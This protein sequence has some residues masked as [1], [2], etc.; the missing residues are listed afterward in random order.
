M[1]VVFPA[2]FSPTNPKTV[3]AGTSRLRLSNASFDP[4]RRV[5]SRIWTAEAVSCWHSA[6]CSTA[7]R[8]AATMVSFLRACGNHGAIALVQQI[9]QILGGDIQLICLSK[10]RID[11]LNQ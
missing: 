2:P 10:Q 11:A 5:T 6:D 9:D 3:P 7:M 8:L 4:N 1:S